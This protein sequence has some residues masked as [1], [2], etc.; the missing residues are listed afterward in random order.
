MFHM[1][2]QR[3]WYDILHILIMYVIHYQHFYIPMVIIHLHIFVIS[4]F[5]FKIREMDEHGA[6][7]DKVCGRSFTPDAITSTGNVV[8]LHFHSDTTITGAGYSA[9]IQAGETLTSMTS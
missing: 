6:V 8:W 3:F 9:T 7:I 5:C 4:S 2:I 1:H